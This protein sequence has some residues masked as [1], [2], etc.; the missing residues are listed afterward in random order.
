MIAKNIIMQKITN[1]GITV[2]QLGA[3]LV[4]LGGLVG[5]VIND[6]AES[7]ALQESVKGLKD[8]VIEQKQD[9]KEIKKSQE[10]LKYQVYQIKMQV[11]T[12][13]N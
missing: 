9:F 8:V 10:D 4:I 7:A 5:F 13:K 1:L 3:L 2:G 11:N 6:K 12:L